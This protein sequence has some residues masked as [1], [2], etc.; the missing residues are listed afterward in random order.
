MKVVEA[1]K[2]LRMHTHTEEAKICFKCPHK[3]SCPVAGKA[4][5]ALPSTA[6][7]DMLTHFEALEKMP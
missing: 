1:S 2:R 5:N 3:L 7:Q 4:P 6:I